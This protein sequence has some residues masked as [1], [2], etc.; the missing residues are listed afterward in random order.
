MLSTNSTGVLSRYA[1]F[2]LVRRLFPWA[3][4]EATSYYVAVAVCRIPPQTRNGAGSQD[5]R[6][7]DICRLRF[8]YSVYDYTYL[9]TLNMI[10]VVFGS[11]TFP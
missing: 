7:I 9:I 3:G 2:F 1:F 6:F 4:R 8:P 11:E 5:R 10:L